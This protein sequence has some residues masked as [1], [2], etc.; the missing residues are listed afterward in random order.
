MIFGYMI[1]IVYL[2]QQKSF[3]LAISALG[4]RTGDQ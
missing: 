4:I 2:C 1:A 3:M